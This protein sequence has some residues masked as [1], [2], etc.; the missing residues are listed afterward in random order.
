MCPVRIELA[1]DLGL[2][3]ASTGPLLDSL[4]QR[5]T[6]TSF[7][8]PL[9]TASLSTASL[10][11]AP[12]QHQ[13]NSDTQMKVANTT[14]STQT[15][16]VAS[17]TST[18]NTTVNLTL[19]V[20]DKPET[21]VGGA[22]DFS[23]FSQFS[24]P[25]SL[26]P[27]PEN[28]LPPLDAGVGNSVNPVQEHKDAVDSFGQAELVSGLAGDRISD[29]QGQ[30]DAKANAPLS[31]KVEQQDHVNGKSADVDDFFSKQLLNATERRYGALT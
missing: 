24:K 20:T 19:T 12:R 2:D 28:S 11:A 21:G 30:A 25:G 6:V 13:E 4:L 14:L 5:A 22:S 27:L 16:P 1:R 18:T 15:Q 23:P 3:S 9:S 10:T 31:L 26:P 7:Q 17:N 8:Q 29:S